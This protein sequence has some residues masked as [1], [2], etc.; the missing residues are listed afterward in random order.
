[1]NLSVC[2]L[3]RRFGSKTAV[4]RV[5]FDVKPGIVGLLGPNGAGKTTLIR[6]LCDL[7]HPNEG[8]VLL[9]GQDIHQMGAE[10]RSILGYVPQKIGFYP[11]F[12]GEK[13]LRYLATLKGLDKTQAADRIGLLLEKVG[14]TAEAGK[15][16]GA[17]SGGMLQRIGI[18]QALLN[19]PKVLILDEPTAG[20]DPQERIRF[21]TLI[22]GLAQDRLVL[23]STHIVSDVEH[24]ATQ[25]LILKDGQLL[26]QD[27]IVR[28]CQPFSGQV[29]TLAVPPEQA[30]WYQTRYAV[31]NMQPAEGL[32]RLRM[33]CL[34]GI[35]KGAVPVTPGLEDAY[36][37]LCR[38]EE[39][40]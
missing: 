4:N 19:D 31:T 29:C 22:A 36:L 18:A 39:A 30:A 17:Y 33:V 7:L 6:M 25:V 9:D 23:L 37:A 32:I 26:A 13:Y 10:Y 11:W 27:S 14:L 16:L 34:G 40:E 20:L 5:N 8:S 28:I 2:D 35:P 12:T 24:I 15:R 38:G 21:R 1:M 3:T